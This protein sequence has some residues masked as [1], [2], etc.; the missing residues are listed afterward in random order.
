MR[1]DMMT[2]IVE[3]IR[4]LVSKKLDFDIPNKAEIFYVFPHSAT[5]DYLIKYS[6]KKDR[7]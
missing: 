3:R 7:S 5:F 1:A 4:L 6:T 2:W